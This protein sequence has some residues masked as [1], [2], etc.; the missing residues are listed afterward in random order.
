MERADA[1]KIAEKAA[2]KAAKK[3]SSKSNKKGVFGTMVTQEEEDADVYCEKC[4]QAYTDAEADIWIGCDS[5]ESWW[6]YQCDGLPAMLTEE[7]EWLC[8]YCL[9]RQPF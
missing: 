5:C 2:K 7:D 3:I 4:T 1:R 6:H 9:S 8:D